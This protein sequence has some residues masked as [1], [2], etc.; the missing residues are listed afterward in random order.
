MRSGPMEFN[1][2]FRWSLVHIDDLS[3]GSWITRIWTKFDFLSS[4]FS[5]LSG[6]NVNKHK[7]PE[8]CQIEARDSWLSSLY[9]DI[10]F[11]SF[12]CLFKT[13]VICQIFACLRES[14][15]VRVEKI[16]SKNHNLPI[17]IPYCS[18]INL[19]PSLTTCWAVSQLATKFL[20]GCCSY[21][22]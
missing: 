21:I 13:S 3:R 18:M 14:R 19:H 2:S 17:Y 5:H 22:N 8:L 7:T 20:R 4:K 10:P 15:Y 11:Y 12:L 16:S 6:S 1:I 9:F